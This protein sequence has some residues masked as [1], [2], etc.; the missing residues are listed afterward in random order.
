MLV[1]GVVLGGH[2]GHHGV[3][4][5]LVQADQE[6]PLR[7]EFTD[8]RSVAVDDATGEGWLVIGDALEIRQIAHESQVEAD[9]RPQR[10]E[11]QQTG[12]GGEELHPGR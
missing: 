1:E 10:C 6:A 7:V 11:S 5:N 4:G 8:Q 9:G 2:E 3:A 12:P